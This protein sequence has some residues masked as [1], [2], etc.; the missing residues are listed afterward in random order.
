MKIKIT[1]EFEIG[2]NELLVNVDDKTEEMLRLVL[3][4]VEQGP[5]NKLIIYH[6]S[7]VGKVFQ[8]L[9]RLFH[10]KVFLC[11]CNYFMYTQMRTPEY[12]KVLKPCEKQAEI[13]Q[14]R[15]LQFGAV[16]RKWGDRMR[17]W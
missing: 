11:F 14:R 5:I 8:R 3:E 16:L 7:E 9:S 6:D 17:V 15:V 12:T 2:R 1:N 4:K 10:T 13:Y